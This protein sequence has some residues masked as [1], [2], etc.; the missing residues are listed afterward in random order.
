M[1][2]A[3]ERAGGL[4]GLGTV[5]RAVQLVAPTQRPTHLLALG[6]GLGQ[7]PHVSLPQGREALVPAPPPQGQTL[8]TLAR[9][10]STAVVVPLA[11]VYY[12][13]QKYF[14]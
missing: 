1:G 2:Q 10:P 5:R 11:A 9:P 14:R 4:V 7:L 13:L 3:R 8:S 12:V 6:A